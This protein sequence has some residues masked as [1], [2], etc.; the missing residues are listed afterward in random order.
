MLEGGG[1]IV[2]T[3]GSRWRGPGHCAI[4]HEKNGDKIVYHAYDANAGGAS[5]LRIALLN[6]DSEGWPTITKVP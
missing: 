3:G 2:V 6:W 1:T 4:L 5:T